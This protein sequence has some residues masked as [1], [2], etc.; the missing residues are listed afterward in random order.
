MNIS[1]RRY[2]TVIILNGFFGKDLCPVAP[3]PIKSQSTLKAAWR[4]EL[5]KLKGIDLL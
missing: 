3:M 5:L 4:E 1:L 2:K